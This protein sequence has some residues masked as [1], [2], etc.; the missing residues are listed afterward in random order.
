MGLPPTSISG[1][2]V[3]SVSG[4]RRSP[5]PAARIMA[6]NGGL[7]WSACRLHSLNAS[8]TRY[9]ELCTAITIVSAAHAS[10]L[11]SSLSTYLLRPAPHH[12][13]AGGDWRPGALRA[14]PVDRPGGLSVDA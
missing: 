8:A 3:V 11:Q 14:G 1:L 13:P 7:H 4:R 6:R 12:R 5:R 2:G 9:T 10:S